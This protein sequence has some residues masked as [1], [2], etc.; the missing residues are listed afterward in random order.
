MPHPGRTRGRIGC[1][2]GHAAELLQK[3]SVQG[4]DRDQLFALILFKNLCPR[5]FE[6]IRVGTSS[7]DTVAAE[8]AR[9]VRL[10]LAQ[11]E[12]EIAHCEDSIAAHEG[13]DVRARK[14]ARLLRSRLTAAARVTR[15]GGAISI[16]SLTAA[17]EGFTDAQL[18]GPAFWEALAGDESQGLMVSTSSGPF[19]IQP[20]DYALFLGPHY[21][22]T[23]VQADEKDARAR[24]TQAL[25][26]LERLRNATWKD[27]ASEPALSVADG[28]EP[29]DFRAA[30][31]NLL[32]DDFVRELVRGGY[33]DHNFSLY[34]TKFHGKILTAAAR[35]YQVQ[36]IDHHHAEPL[37]HLT[38]SDVDEL[39]TR[40]DGLLA[41][42]A[43][44]L[45]VYVLARLLSIGAATHAIGLLLEKPDSEIGDFVVSYLNTPDLD[46]DQLIHAIV[47][48]WP[49]AIDLFCGTDR[50]SD[51]ARRD[52]L[53]TVLASLSDDT[54]YAIAE[55]SA[56]LIRDAFETLPAIEQPMTE[57]SAEAVADVAQR[58]GVQVAHLENLAQ[59]LRSAMGER[60]CF[61][62]TRAA[63]DALVD[64]PGRI[65][66]DAMMEAGTG[67]L[68]FVVSR[69]ADYEAAL[70]APPRANV[71]ADTAR[72]EDV[73]TALAERPAAALELVLRRSAPDIRFADLA[74]APVETIALLG[75]YDRF[76][77]TPGNL[78]VLAES[79]E[80]FGEIYAERLEARPSID[81]DEE[82]PQ[83][84][85]RE[86]AARLVAEPLLSSAAQL[87]L[88]ESLGIESPL[89]LAE[90]P[91]SH[92]ET[93]SGLIARDLLVP[94]ATTLNVALGLG[95]AYFL[96]AARSC[97]D[98]SAL[99]PAIAFE[100]DQLASVIALDSP[101]HSIAQAVLTNVTGLQGV[102]GAN[103][104][105][106][107]LD[108]ATAVGRGLTLPELVILVDA[109]ASVQ[110]VIAYLGAAGDRVAIEDAIEVL[111]RLPLPYSRLVDGND[112]SVDIDMSDGLETLVD[113]LKR[114]GV[115]TASRLVSQRSK[116]RVTPT[117]H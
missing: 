50:L 27:L 42:D 55:D 63:L 29:V 10:R 105:D 36:H 106:A 110:R 61:T 33:I 69:I 93:L 107:L 94:D 116:L 74:Q 99:I 58:A 32:G 75:E 59:P 18:D 97:A 38:N 5:D 46:G 21:P 2:A 19:T 57:M 53:N 8:L 56:R 9:L 81:V 17:G 14:A 45:N 54:E 11:L 80:G 43:S 7:L 6:H 3:S 92:P 51:A 102:I 25:D 15:G 89:T 113:R 88:V 109:Q 64:A 108:A 49:G 66:L 22:L 60:G 96:A 114:R 117:P 41:R 70:D 85:R 100:A 84:V 12:A 111:R 48:R 95:D 1:L 39:L 90:L 28:E 98:L 37:F 87:R 73:V 31:S 82:C 65:G 47:P 67:L 62:V 23:W 24:L 35:T 77:P 52:H 104:A 71:L 34:T 26:L 79:S 72:F 91:L 101:R 16:H 40:T 30:I 13:L 78:I 115:V 20:D 86:L 76:P 4:L 103:T 112:T 68:T 44:A 83:E